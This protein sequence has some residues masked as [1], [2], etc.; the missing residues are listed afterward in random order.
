[1]GGGGGG[2]PQRVENFTFISVP[3]YDNVILFIMH[4]DTDFDYSL[5][6]KSNGMYVTLKNEYFNYCFFCTY[7]TSRLVGCR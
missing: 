6:D 2:G 5:V 3:C 4:S 7:G 1:V